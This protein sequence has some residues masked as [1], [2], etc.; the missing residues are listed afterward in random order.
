MNKFKLNKE[1]STVDELL[2][3]SSTVVDSALVKSNEGL[4]LL[5]KLKSDNDIM[6]FEWLV[7]NQQLNNDLIENNIRNK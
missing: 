5:V 1:V 3:N 7:P 4:K 6:L 2:V